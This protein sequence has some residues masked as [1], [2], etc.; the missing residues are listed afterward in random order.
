MSYLLGFFF[1]RFGKTLRDLFPERRASSI[2]AAMLC[3]L[4]C[5]DASISEIFLLITFCEVP[6]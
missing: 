5:P 2:A 3:F 6:F 4:G 1:N